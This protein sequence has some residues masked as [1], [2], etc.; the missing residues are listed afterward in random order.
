MI[1]ITGNQGCCP[2]L[3]G[4][5]LMAVLGPGPE[6]RSLDLTVALMPS[7]WLSYF[8]LHGRCF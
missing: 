3:G 8:M 4:I 7:V 5:V 1:I 2:W 6:P